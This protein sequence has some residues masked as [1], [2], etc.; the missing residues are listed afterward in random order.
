MVVPESPRWLAMQ[1][2]NKEALQVIA[3][4]HSDGETSHPDALA[5]YQEILDRI[6]FERTGGRQI[7]LK[8]IV[9]TP[10][11]RMRLILVVS[12]SVCAMLSG[13]N[14]VSFYLGDLLNNAGITDSNTQLQIVSRFIHTHSFLVDW[15][16]NETNFAKDYHHERM[17]SGCFHHRHSVA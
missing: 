3:L 11:L 9:K 5:A 12:A 6:E 4:L 14:I 13:N 17:V 8:H 2:R 16:I 10:D 15:A 1:D 7:S